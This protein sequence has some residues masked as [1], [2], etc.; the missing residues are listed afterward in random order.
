MAFTFSDP[1]AWRRALYGLG[2]G[3]MAR[4]QGAPFSAGLMQGFQNY[5][6]GQQADLQRKME[7]ERLKL[8][9]QEAVDRR[10]AASKKA[11]FANKISAMLNPGIGAPNNGR[12][13]GM[14]PQAQDQLGGLNIPP[15]LR[16]ILGEAAQYDPEGAYATLMKFAMDKPDQFKPDLQTF[17]DQGITHSGYFDQ[18]G[19]WV[20]KGASPQWQPQ[21]PQ[22]PQSVNLLTLVGP[23][24]DTVSVDSR[25][26]RVKELVNGGYVERQ[27]SMF[28]APPSGYQVAPNGSGLQP[29]P[30][31]PADP[32]RLTDTQRNEFKKQSLALDNLDSALNDYEAA[33]TKYGAI[34]TYGEG[35]GVLENAYANL[36]IQ[37]KE[38]ANL[39]ALTGPDMNIMGQMIIP[40][41]SVKAGMVGGADAVK[42]QMNNARAQLKQKRS[43]LGT[44]YGPNQSSGGGAANDPLNLR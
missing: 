20:E 41:N 27:P 10:T 26:P 19:Q 40:P 1:S 36:L 24:G 28:P 32:N 3:L 25:D 37:M 11:E 38:A 29:T 16:S 21:Q 23:N 7:E 34:E 44:I 9:Q 8:A 15:Q 42:K 31:G 17:N 6:A 13:G 33:L 22:Q 43:N 5:D 4:S 12:P 14:A 2:G 39:G 30:G 35:K 18:S